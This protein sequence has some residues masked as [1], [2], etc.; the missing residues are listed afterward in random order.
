LFRR[1]FWMTSRNS[2]AYWNPGTGISSAPTR[3]YA[4]RTLRKHD[5]QLLYIFSYSPSIHY[6]R[7]QA[8]HPNQEPRSK[9]R[10]GMCKHVS[11]SERSS[12]LPSALLIWEPTV[13]DFKHMCTI[14]SAAR[15]AL[16]KNPRLSSDRSVT[17]L[18]RLIPC[19]MRAFD[20]M[21]DPDLAVITDVSSTLYSDPHDSRRISPSGTPLTR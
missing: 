15:T 16:I 2:E 6:F 8:R 11:R 7:Y 17:S 5:C 13:C 4:R 21:I 20:N 9:G 3:A 1:A 19:K 12:V 14:L 10:R 18:L